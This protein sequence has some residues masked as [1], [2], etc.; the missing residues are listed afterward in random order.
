MYKQ[1][2]IISLFCTAV[3]F[4]QGSFVANLNSNDIIAKM[5]EYIEAEKVLEAEAKKIEQQVESVQEE[6]DKKYEIYR[7]NVASYS[8]DQRKA[9]EEEMIELEKKMSQIQREGQEKLR[10]KEEELLAPIIKKLDEAILFVANDLRYDYVLDTAEGN[11]IL[12]NSPKDDITK[13]VLQKLGISEVQEENKEEKN[14]D[15]YDW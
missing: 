8:N 9:A 4:G 2:I 7:N 14:D 12:V 3:I 6:L 15:P 1:I 5:P 10:E 11:T 13:Y